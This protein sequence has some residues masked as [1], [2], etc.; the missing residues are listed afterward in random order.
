MPH[1][2][3]SASF[4]D[5]FSRGLGENGFSLTCEFSYFAAMSPSFG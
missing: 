3:N 4:A 1:S 2:Y 5:W